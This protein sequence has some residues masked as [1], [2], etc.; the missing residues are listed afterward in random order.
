VLDQFRFE[1]AVVPVSERLPVILSNENLV[2]IES[3]FIPHMPVRG[4]EKTEIH[5]RDRAIHRLLNLA[6]YG[7]TPGRKA[8]VLGQVVTIH[9]REAE[10]CQIDV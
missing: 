8:S 9:S 3:F 10:R 2:R 6:N 4:N 5:I 7:E 1:K